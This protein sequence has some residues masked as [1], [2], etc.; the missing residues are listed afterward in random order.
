MPSDA[1][2]IQFKLADLGVAKLFHEVDAKNTR[3]QW[4]L[5][6][7]VVRPEEFGPVDYHI[8]LYHVGLFLLQLAL[9]REATFTL[10]EV[11]AGKPRQLAETLPPPLNFALEKAL[12]RHVP[13]RTSSAMELW[14]D[15]RASPPTA[16]LELQTPCT[17]Q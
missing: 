13:Y 2:V 16:L 4:M 11:L 14:R 6:P 9:S 10:E 17:P 1:K 7:E 12:R 15:L 5:P 8:D 3:A